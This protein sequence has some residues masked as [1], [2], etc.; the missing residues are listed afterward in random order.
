VLSGGVQRLA[1]AVGKFQEIRI[2]DIG[3][4]H[5]IDMGLQ[6]VLDVFPEAKD[7]VATSAVTS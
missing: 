3:R 1:M 2:G 7:A 6:Q 5:Q 4:A